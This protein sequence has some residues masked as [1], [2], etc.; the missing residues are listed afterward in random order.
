M[1]VFSIENEDVVKIM[2]LI[3]VFHLDDVV[4]C[5]LCIKEACPVRRRQK[6]L[7]RFM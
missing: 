3:F 4:S 2:E 6:A 1:D 5:R 7:W